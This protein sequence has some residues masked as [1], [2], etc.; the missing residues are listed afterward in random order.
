[1]GEPQNEGQRD[2]AVVSIVTLAVVTLAILIF[3]LRVAVPWLVNAR[4]DGLLL[5]AGVLGLSAI[6]FAYLMGRHLWRSFL[7]MGDPE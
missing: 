3:V 7:A 5:L 2:V 6:V 4:N 1:M